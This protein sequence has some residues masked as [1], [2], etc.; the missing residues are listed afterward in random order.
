MKTNNTKKALIA[1]LLSLVLCVSMLVGSTFAWFTD[2][3]TTAVNT[4]Q[5]GNLKIDIVNEAGVSLKGSDMSFVNKDGSAD[6]L[7][8]PGA[9]F[10]TPGFK[11]K[12][13]GNLALKYK[14]L[15]NGVT[16]DN[17][18]LKVIKFSVVDENGAVVNLDSYE[19]VLKKDETS[20][21]LYI[22]GHMAED[23][24]NTYQ[25]LKL[26]GLGITVY[27]TQY[28]DE[29][30]SN[31]SDYDKDATYPIV[32]VATVTVDESG[33]TTEKSELTST[34]SSTKVT[35]PAGAKVDDTKLVLTIHEAADPENFTVKATDVSQTLE[36][37]MVGLAEDN[38]ELIR[39]VMNVGKSLNGFALY[40][41]G[42]AMTKKDTVADLTADQDYYYDSAKGEVTML[43][44]HFSPFTYTYAKGDWNDQLT[45]DADFETP[46]DTEK[47]V[48]T[49]ASASE[50][51]LFAK[52]ITDKGK[53]YSGYTVNIVADI[54][55]SAGL[56]K[57]INGWGKM[58]HIVIN[59]NGHTIKNMIVRD[60]IN[61]NSGG[62]GAGFIGQTSGSITIENLT[63]DSANVAFPHAEWY[64]G[65]V[66]NVGG[67]VMGYT[68]GTTLFENVSVV[69]STIQGY[70]KIGC[71]LGMGAD[72]GVKVTFR[73][74]VSKNNTI[75]AVYN[76]GGLAG[77]I[78][79][80]NGVDNT[81]VENCTVENIVVEYDANEK[82]ADLVNVKVT[83][84]TNDVTEDSTVEKIVSGKYWICQGYYW[85]GYADY[86]VSYGDSAYDAPAEGHSMKLAN[87]E[88]DVNK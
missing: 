82:Y 54:D 11:V 32:A 34:D 14:M 84:S 36:V 49:I 79:R 76:M 15:L 52:Q 50:L 28:A 30:D 31:G 2:T 68:Y 12:N 51:A 55:L 86:Y 20:G 81:T 4:I 40:H 65:Y 39:V 57:P 85:G 18:L 3:A 25:G 61:P 10:R 59:G 71:L 58:D 19:A 80:G 48:V 27:A 42:T 22:E 6:I 35:V 62:Y 88:Y 33:K 72:P 38:T 9:T 83:Y 77:N 53:N 47:K 21:V 56:W 29:S 5:A 78:Q 17:E 8:E 13:I 16:G 45:D 70:G 7:W 24:G 67:V 69:N 74:C 26:N 87:G 75:H 43:T 63:F 37:K 23:A 73:D 60:C 46:V 1:S 44:S 66:G 41:N 64:N